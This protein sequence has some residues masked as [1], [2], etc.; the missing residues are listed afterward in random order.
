MLTE[1]PAAL[2]TLLDQSS[3]QDTIL[4]GHALAVAQQLP[5]HHVDCIISSPPYFGHRQYSD[6]PEQSVFEIGREDDPQ[7]YVSKIAAVFT[8]LRRV[9][10][11]TGTLWLNIGDTY[12][13]EQLLGIPWRVALALQ[14]SGWILRSEIIWHKPNAMPSSVKNRPTTDH[15]HIFL[16]CQSKDYYYDADA[17]R[18]PHVT[19]SPE[20]Q[21]KGGRNHFGKACGTPEAGKN[22]GNANL[23]R[24]R[25]DQ[26]FHPLGRNKR[27]VWAIPLGKFREVHFAVFPEPLV[28]TCLLAA[29][30]EHG[31]VLDPFMGSGTTAVVAKRLGRHYLG[32]ELV[33]AYA[34]MAQARLAKTQAR[35]I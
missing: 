17:I 32:I 24:G 26:A 34:A 9:L 3:L 28:E 4:V 7:T 20:S 29:T 25:W 33:P 13:D 11:P 18:E 5:T 15:E 22:G 1:N 19:F 16:F 27:T 14:D 8:E 30:P 23:H 31:L 21:M 35:L 2:G 10:R 6:Q 12:R